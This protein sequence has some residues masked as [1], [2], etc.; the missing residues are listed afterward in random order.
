MKENWE[1]IEQSWIFDNFYFF[2]I[3]LILAFGTLQTT[4][5]VMNTEKPV[6]T[7][8][9]C[10][11]YPQLD[12]GD[13]LLVH[14]K[15]FENYN[16]G[17]IIVFKVPGQSESVVHRIIRKSPES[18]ET[19]GDNNNQQLEFEKNIRP[20]HVQGEV[21]FKVPRIGLVKLLTLDIVGYGNEP[22][23]L[24]STPQCFERT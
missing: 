10:S 23:V 11:M 22:L 9:S 13:V 4:G 24:D 15:Q 5:A 6:V 17:E 2:A 12:V 8:I 14:G 3:A 21:F 7:V 19:K 18:L 1:K 16:E 20:E